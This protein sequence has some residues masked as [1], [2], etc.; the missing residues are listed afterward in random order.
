MKKRSLGDAFNEEDARFVKILEENPSYVEL[1]KSIEFEGTNPVSL[2]FETRNDGQNPMAFI[3]Y[4]KISDNELKPQDVSLMLYESIVI[5]NRPTDIKITDL[6]EDIKAG[7][8]E[9]H[10]ELMSSVLDYTNVLR[11]LKNN[12]LESHL[13]SYSSLEAELTERGYDYKKLEKYEDTVQTLARTALMNNTKE[14]GSC[15]L[16][17]YSHVVDHVLTTSFRE[18]MTKESNLYKHMF[19]VMDKC[20]VD[21]PKQKRKMKP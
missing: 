13:L 10:P 8:T 17:K 18:K 16:K 14:D 3:F 1:D 12:V 9:P 7:K 19:E 4:K 11:V 5:N 20:K 15:P 6:M 21:S 2:K